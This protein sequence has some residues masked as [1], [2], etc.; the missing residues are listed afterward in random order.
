MPTTILGGVPHAT[1]SDDIYK[2]YLIPKGAGVMNNVWAIN[3]D[4]TRAPIP[5]KFDPTRYEKDNLSLYDSTSNPDATK[6]DHFT[7][8]AG[9]RICPGK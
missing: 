3:M 8:G 5:R 9:R 2:G 6:R 1:T 4:P 7:F